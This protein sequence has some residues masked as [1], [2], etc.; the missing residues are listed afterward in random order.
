MNK[1]DHEL[2]LTVAIMTV[3]YYKR[4]LSH[5]WAWFSNENTKHV[6]GNK[7]PLRGQIGDDKPITLDTPLLLSC[8]RSKIRFP[9]LVPKSPKTDEDFVHE[10][11]SYLMLLDFSML[12]IWLVLLFHEIIYVVLFVLVV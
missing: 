11:Y 9:H 10:P 2:R 3:P 1:L 6:L 8:E 12:V 4:S 7:L 5:F